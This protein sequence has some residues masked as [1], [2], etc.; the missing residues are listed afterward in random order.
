MLMKRIAAIAAATLAL[1]AAVPGVAMAG[2]ASTASTAKPIPQPVQLACPRLVLARAPH[3]RVHKG[4]VHKGA[5]HK[6]RAFP[7]PGGK[8]GFPVICCAPALV[9]G[10]LPFP[11]PPGHGKPVHGKPVHGKPGPVFFR[12]CQARLLTFDMPAFGS[13]ATEVSGP[14][15]SAHQLVIYRSNLYRIGSVQGQ[16]FTLD[17]LGPPFIPGG[18]LFTNG[19]TPIVDGR[20]TVLG[21]V[22]VIVIR[23]RLAKS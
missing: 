11:G 19:P 4:A 12:V 8:L 3:G 13:T 1:T 17:R 14:H 5:V 18:Q 21:R 10:R 20:A 7:V 15:L 2:T 16:N 6:G 9:K 23:G 22:T